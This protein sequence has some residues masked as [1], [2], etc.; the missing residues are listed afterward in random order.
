MDAA[1]RERDLEHGLLNHIQKFLVGLGVGFA[2]AFVGRQYRLEVSREEFFLDLLFYHLRL[3]CYVVVDLKMEA[4][5][6]EFAGKMN[7][8]LSAVDDQLR[9]RDDQPSI[10]LLLCKEIQ[11]QKE[12][13]GC[14]L[15]AI[16]SLSRCVLL[17]LPAIIVLWLVTGLV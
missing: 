9:H 7:F 13:L 11:R 5:K 2:F 6:P 8:Y 12:K 17:F 15:P 4:F 14:R 16:A 3:R 10:G 1:A